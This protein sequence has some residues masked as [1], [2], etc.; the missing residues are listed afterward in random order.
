MQTLHRWKAQALVD[1]GVRKGSTSRELS[2]L[3][4]A[5]KRIKELEDE[6]RL[7]KDAC[8]IFDSL[9]VVDPKKAGRRDRTRRARP[10][11]TQSHE[12]CWCPTFHVRCQDKAQAAV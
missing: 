2:D 1:A 3:R 6:L 10:F 7:V 11:P 8:E 9:A 12:N 4:E 5:R